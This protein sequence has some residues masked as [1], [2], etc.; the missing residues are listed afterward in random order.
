LTHPADFFTSTSKRTVGRWSQ[1]YADVTVKTRFLTTDIDPVAETYVKSM[2]IDATYKDGRPA[3]HIVDR[4]MHRMWL[5]SG[6][7]HV[8][9]ASGAF[10]VLAWY[11]DLSPRVPLSV[12]MSSWRMVTVLRRRN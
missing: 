2:K 4:Q 11:G 7:S 6:I 5:R 8:V 9:A 10:D 12:R 3:K 1:R